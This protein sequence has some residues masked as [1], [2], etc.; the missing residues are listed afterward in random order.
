[1]VRRA[2]RFV[3]WVVP[4]VLLALAVA[5]QWRRVRGDAAHQTPLRRAA[6]AGT[7]RGGP[8]RVT[9]LHRAPRRPGTTLWK[10][11]DRSTGERHGGTGNRARPPRPAHR[12]PSGAGPADDGRPAGSPRV[13]AQAGPQHLPVPEQVRRSQAPD[14]APRE[15]AAAPH[16]EPDLIEV[17][18]LVDDAEEQRERLRSAGLRVGAV[19]TELAEGEGGRVLR[20]SPEPGTRVPRGGIVDLVV[21]EAGA[22]VGDVRELT[23]DAARGRLTRAGFKVSRRSVP[24]PDGVR[25]GTVLGQEPEAGALAPVGSVVRLTVARASK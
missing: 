3:F 20:S 7:P 23:A 14:D 19:R 16:E 15:E 21:S 8:S 22:R 11:P 18:G 12:H 4:L 17:P 9:P 10:A 5:R 24:P 25:P 2:R 1:M 6:R 13:P